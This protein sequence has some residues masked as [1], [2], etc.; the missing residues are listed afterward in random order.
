MFCLFKCSNSRSFRLQS[1]YFILLW[2]DVKSSR[3]DFS[4]ESRRVLFRAR[5]PVSIAQ[6][7][8]C[9]AYFGN[10]YFSLSPLFNL[11]IRSQFCFELLTLTEIPGSV[12]QS[13]PAV[14]AVLFVHFCFPVH[15]FVFCD[16][17]Y[18]FS[19]PRVHIYIHMERLS[20]LNS[21]IS[22]FR[23]TTLE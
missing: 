23:R 14:A 18:V 8:I 6:K 11:W 17:N 21:G 2:S 1:L 7:E 5:N 9:L 12:L 16:V 3:K 19:L 10:F 20:A 22:N 4:S 15:V 13:I